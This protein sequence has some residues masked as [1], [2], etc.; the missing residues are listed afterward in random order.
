M[1]KTLKFG[2]LFLLCFV[3]SPLNLRLRVIEHEASFKTPLF[4]T[5]NIGAPFS[6]KSKLA[7]AE[8]R[9]ITGKNGWHIDQIKVRT[10]DG[11]QEEMSPNF[12]G[13]GKNPY[14]WKVPNGEH[15]TKILYRKR[16]WLDGVTFVTNKGT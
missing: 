16:S 8:I 13:Y 4:G 15:I 10:F 2:I 14:T 1:D 9:E 5:N 11:S 6:W 3:A 7:R 12:G